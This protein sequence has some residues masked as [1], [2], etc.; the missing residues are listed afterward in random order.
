L[1]GLLVRLSVATL[2]WSAALVCHGEI[3]SDLYSAEVPVADQSRESLTSASRD[4]MADV[5]VKVSG[6]E[7]TLANPLIRS[8]LGNARKQVQQY[9]Y[10]RGEE[11][12]ELY[13]R[14]EFDDSF[15]TDLVA[16]AGE[17]LWTANRPRVLVWLVLEDSAGRQFVSHENT[18]E[19]AQQL[20]REFSRRGVPLQ[21]P[22][23]DLAD[24]AAISTEEAW[25]LYGP[26]L[27][28]A[29]KRYNVQDVLAGRLASLSTGSWVGDWSYL[30]GRDRSDRSFTA[31]NSQGF[32]REGASLVAEVMAGRYAIAPTAEPGAGVTMS[33]TGVQRYAD[34]AK[35]VSWLEKL[36]LVEHAN[37]E[38]IRGDEILLRLH[39]QAEATQL[40]AIIELNRRFQPLPSLVSGAELSYQWQN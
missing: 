21:L 3:V 22:L 39:A 16:R 35:I 10:S 11:Q 28:S 27:Q 5:L 34:Y 33:V 23:Y 15:I 14:F 30:H 2:L 29:S 1:I 18:P 7:D 38:E 37:V 6:S 20:I 40:A 26:A 31:P 13:V 19:M 12:G 25:R 4:A 36:E 32:A 9:A 8:E 24:S 17:P